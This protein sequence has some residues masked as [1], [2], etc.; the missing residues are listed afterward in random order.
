MKA[1]KS[2]GQNFLKNKSVVKDIVRA[3][4][5]KKEDVVLEIG[6][7]K[8]ILTI[9]LLKSSSN[10]IAIEKDDDLYEYLKE[11]FSD[12]VRGEKLN[13]IH[14]DIL[15]EELPEIKNYKLIANI[16]YNITGQI[17]KKFLSGKN[18]PK[19][20][21]LLIQKEVAERIVA[22]DGKE[23]ILSMSVKAYGQP[24]FIKKVKAENFSPKPRVDSAILLIENISKDFFEDISEEKFLLDPKARLFLMVGFC[25]AF[26][27]FSTF[28]LETAKR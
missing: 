5:L 28:M 27:T 22:K 16:P 6:P 7:G 1:K 18:Q 23:S 24:K 4:D 14:G 25:G 19:L 13:L 17:L 9:E 2:L 20:I 21:A 26:T 8:G 11:K 15:K 3:S 10:V 12:E